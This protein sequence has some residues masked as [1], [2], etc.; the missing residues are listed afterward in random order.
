M[1]RFLNCFTVK[2]LC[3]TGPYVG[4]QVLQMRLTSLTTR[5][6]T[7]GLNISKA[8]ITHIQIFFTSLKNHYQIIHPRLM[9][10]Y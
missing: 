4:I 3:E 8:I 10:L 2:W 6:G 9:I 7:N 1:V 5:A